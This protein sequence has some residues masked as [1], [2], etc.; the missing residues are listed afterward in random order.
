M[1]CEKNKDVNTTLLPII[2][3]AN[4]EYTTRL[5]DG[6]TALLDFSYSGFPNPELFLNFDLMFEIESIKEKPPSNACCR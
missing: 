1:E 6:R 2:I 5:G 4:G 3:G